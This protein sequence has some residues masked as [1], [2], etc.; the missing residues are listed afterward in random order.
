M[1]FVCLHF[2]RQYYKKF[3]KDSL[4]TEGIIAFAYKWKH[5]SSTYII[6]NI[7]SSFQKLLAMYSLSCFQSSNPIKMMIFSIKGL[8]QGPMYC[9]QHITNSVENR[10]K[11]S[12]GFPCTCTNQT[13]F[14]SIFLGKVLCVFFCPF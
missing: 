14:T 7:E 10:L 3:Y 9:T 6:T 2:N 4:L 8:G 13:S 11:T 5:I 12:I 1:I